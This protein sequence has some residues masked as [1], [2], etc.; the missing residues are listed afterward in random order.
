MA[1]VKPR[2]VRLS[3]WRRMSEGERQAVLWSKDD[4]THRRTIAPQTTP[5]KALPRSRCRAL[6]G[7]L[8]GWIE[9]KRKTT[10]GR[11]YCVYRSPFGATVMS[12]AAALRM[13]IGASN[14]FALEDA[15]QVQ[16]DPSFEVF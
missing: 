3:V 1:R 10:S 9:E 12:K 14:A 13:V 11:V 5:Q 15:L 8:E 2:G 6:D 4:A 7:E 16:P